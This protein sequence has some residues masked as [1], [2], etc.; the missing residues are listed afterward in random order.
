MAIQDDW[1]VDYGAKT[2]AHS[3][4]T[5]IYTVNAFY[6]WL[7]DLF[8]EIAQ[9]DDPVPMSAQ[10]PTD[11]SLINGWVFGAAIDIQFLKG[12][13]I[14]D[15]SDDTVWANIYTAGAIVG[16][17]NIYIEQNGAVLTKFWGTDHIDVLI[18]VKDAGTFIDS[19]NL[20]LYV[21]ES[22][23]KYAWFEVTATGGRN[24][25]LLQSEDDVNDDGTGGAVTGVVMGYVGGYAADID[26]D[27]LNETYDIQVDCGGNSLVDVYKFLKDLVVM[28]ST[29]LVDGVQGQMYR[30]ADPTYTANAASPFGNLAGGK[31]FGA[32]GV[33]LINMAGSDSNNYQLIDSTGTSRVP[34]STVSVTIDK[35]V[36]GDRVS[37]F[38]LSAPGGTIINNEYTLN[39]AHSSGATSI[40]VNEAIKTDTPATGYIRVA[41][42]SMAYS[43]V[44]TAAK[45]FT[46]LATSQA[47]SSG[48]AA[49]VPFIDDIAASTS[50]SN[51]LKYNADVPV[52]IRV[53][54][55]GIQPFEIES[56]I[57]DVGV[58][59]SAIRTADNVVV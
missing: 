35:I 13:A 26:D 4:G 50:I 52:L 2:I 21:R 44:D 40:V 54:L 46:V 1:T 34:P 43:A 20:V 6:S 7:M 24:P 14:T 23:D 17:S 32:R 55:K 51:I 3:A 12:G 37:V 53:R 9:M 59:V 10:T 28:G 39:G 56:T 41:G 36:S 47:F 42:V 45:T 15:T 38:R 49:Y 33:L 30:Y 8:D 57:G 29:T 25:A 5:T 18:K 11:Y 58:T 27:G 16:G 19:G 22:G 48:D 31:F